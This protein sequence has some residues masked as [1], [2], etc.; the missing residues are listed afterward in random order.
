M[1]E[2]INAHA[3]LTDREYSVGD[4]D[5]SDGDDYGDGDYSDDDGDDFDDGG[6][7]DDKM[8]CRM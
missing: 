6:S 7:N 4:D 5:D 1:F 2:K 3:I 8:I